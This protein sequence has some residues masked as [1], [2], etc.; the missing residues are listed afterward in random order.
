MIAAKFCC[1]RKRSAWAIRR[2]IP[3]PM[4]DAS[5]S[6]LKPYPPWRGP[7]PKRGRIKAQ[8]RPV[9]GKGISNCQIKNI[10]FQMLSIQ[11]LELCCYNFKEE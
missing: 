6:K 2:S 9:P 11:A 10:Y 4:H 1:L 3:V 5:V 8:G 7:G